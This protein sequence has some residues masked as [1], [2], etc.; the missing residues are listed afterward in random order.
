MLLES[1]LGVF[2]GSC[3]WKVFLERAHVSSN[4]VHGCSWKAF[5]GGLRKCLRCVLGVQNHC[6][7]IKSNFK[8]RRKR[9]YERS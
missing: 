5:M 6:A 1:D 9:T 3:S 7:G 8:I 2:L 4:G